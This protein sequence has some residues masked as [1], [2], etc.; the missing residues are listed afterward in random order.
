[1]GSSANLVI[2]SATVSLSPYVTAGGAGTFADVGYKRGAVEIAPTYTD[3][4]IKAD[5]VLGTLRRFPTDQK[6]T[7]KFMAIEATVANLQE[8]LRQ[9]DANVSGTPP[10]ETIQLGT[11]EERK[12][13]IKIVGVGLGTGKVRTVLLWH[14]IVQ[15]ASPVGFTKDGEQVLEMEF[16]VLHDDTVVATGKWGTLVET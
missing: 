2:G 7:C 3:Y 13:Q 6:L 14:C 8:W 9:P 11:I 4:E 5:D 16:D 10:D 12:K 15:S 1:M